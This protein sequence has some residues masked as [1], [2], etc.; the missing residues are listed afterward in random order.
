MARV[1]SDS[2]QQL[3][4][5]NS[6]MAHV[7]ERETYPGMAHA[8]V[9][10]HLVEQHRYQGR[11]PIVAMNDLRMFVGLEHELQGGAAKERE[12]FAVIMVAVKD[13]AVEE[14]A[15]QVWLDKKTLQT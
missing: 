12:T 10:V 14:I 5:A 15:I 9:L 11:L 6:L 7:M 2:P 3:F 8:Q 1:Q 13:A 4:T